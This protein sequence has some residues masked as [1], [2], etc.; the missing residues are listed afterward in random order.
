MAWRRGRS[1]RHAVLNTQ[2]IQHVG[3]PV[4]ATANRP[5]VSAASVADEL[6]KLAALKAACVLTDE[7]FNAQ[8]ARLLG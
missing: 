2:T 5:D 7:E 3:Q 1:D 4:P 8:K 6:T